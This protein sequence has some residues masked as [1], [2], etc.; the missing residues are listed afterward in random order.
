MLFCQGAPN[1]I[2]GK[3]FRVVY[4]KSSKLKKERRRMNG[5]SLR[6]RFFVV[7]LIPVC[8]LIGGHY[9]AA[10][11]QGST[12]SIDDK[13]A[14]ALDDILG[15]GSGEEILSTSLVEKQYRI[16]VEYL[17]GNNGRKRDPD[18]AKNWL[19]RAAEAGHAGALY[20][21]G[22]EFADRDALYRSAA[23]DYGP[24]LKAIGVNYYYGQKGF[25][26]DRGMARDWFRKLARVDPKSGNGWL[27]LMGDEDRRAAREREAEER[28]RIAEARRAAEQASKQEEKRLAALEQ[29][30]EEARRAKASAE[31]EVAADRSAA[32]WQDTIEHIQNTGAEIRHDLRHVQRDTARAFHQTEH[33]LERQRRETEQRQEEQ[34]ETNNAIVEAAEREAGERRRQAAV[35]AEN[36]RRETERRRREEQQRLAAASQTNLQAA[37]TTEGR[38]NSNRQAVAQEA[39]NAYADLNFQLPNSPKTSLAATTSNSQRGSRQAIGN[40]NG[41]KEA[42][43]SNVSKTGDDGSELVGDPTV[44]RF[45]QKSVVTG[46]PLFDSPQEGPWGLLF[47]LSNK[48][49]AEPLWP[50]TGF[51]GIQAAAVCTD[52]SA[53]DGNPDV[54]FYMR[55]GTGEK[56]YV[57]AE[58]KVENTHQQVGFS[59]VGRNIPPS[60]TAIRVGSTI[61]KDVKCEMDN[62][63]IFMRARKIQ[64]EKDRGKYVGP[65]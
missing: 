12:T 63:R 37:Q 36:K 11:D 62:M 54:V 19:S 52:S 34:R 5:K 23:S 38:D 15:G 17:Y 29:A 39:S 21:L 56:V 49:L 25:P 40:A 13:A 61:A 41:G 16:G 51:K 22:Y 27:E 18:Q 43:V 28:E 24:A 7:T 1:E 2:V 45:R 53:S 58:F 60:G 33:A 44:A 8:W 55:N 3:L 35:D 32:M 57:F 10:Q 6:R 20:Y 48:P 42:G 9:S 30:Q 46:E 59:T 14:R 4:K 50:M 64:Y 65:Q 31:A 47:H 26:K